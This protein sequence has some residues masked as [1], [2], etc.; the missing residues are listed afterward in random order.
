MFQVFCSF[1]NPISEMKKKN[2][3]KNG[4]KK[5]INHNFFLHVCN[6][7]VESGT[8]NEIFGTYLFWEHIYKKSF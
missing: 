6:L 5:L 4:K 2:S 8:S 7:R 1:F 3:K